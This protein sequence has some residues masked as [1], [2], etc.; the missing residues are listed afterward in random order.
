MR[1]VTQMRLIGLV[2][3]CAAVLAEGCAKKAP[4][5]ARLD[6][7]PPVITEA[8]PPPPP[9]PAPDPPSTPAP[10]L[11]EEE[12]FARKTLEDLNAERPLADALFDLDQSTLR[13]DA[14]VV[15][16]RNAEWLRRWTA[17]R[18]TVEGHCDSRGTSEYNLALG[19]RRG[20]A[21]KDYLVSLGIAADRIVVV[22]KGRESPVCSDE[23]ESCWQQNRRG[24][25]IISAK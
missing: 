16:Q 20:A 2:V 11:T 7:T 9:P 12:I 14:R 10:A 4:Q 8:P 3:L 25:P 1:D 21:V 19:D 13:D 17:T 5:V 15:L 18:I 24:H 6:P 23:N 22:S